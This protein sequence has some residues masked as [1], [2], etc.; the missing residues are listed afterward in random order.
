MRRLAAV[1]VVIL[2]ALERA[3]LLAE[4]PAPEGAARFAPVNGLQ[5]HYEIH[6]SASGQQ[7]PLVLLHG[8]GSTIETTFGKVLPALARR[9][10][11]IAFHQQGHGRTADIADRPFSFEQ[12]ADDAAALVGHLGIEK[13]DFF[14]FSNGGNIALQIAIR[15][16]GRVGK[17]VVASAMY[18]RDGVYPEVWEFIRRSTLRDMPEVL[19]EAYRQTSPHP[20]QL[21]TFHD[22]SAR[23]MVEFKDWRPEDIQSIAA[24]TLLVIGDADSVRPEHAVEMFRLLPHARLAVFPGGHGAYI[25]EASAARTEGSQV[26]FGAPSSPKPDSSAQ[27]QSKLPDLVVAIIEEFLDAPLPQPKA[28]KSTIP[29]PQPKD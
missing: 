26:R 25:G 20:E 28:R 17:L 24:P 23:R 7:P 22:K 3:E 6:G 14:G 27:K 18:K 21:Q 12:S 15:H 8:G 10:Q 9:R 29:P 4:Q 11:V 2:L 19:K 16:P 1:L 13:A 5:M